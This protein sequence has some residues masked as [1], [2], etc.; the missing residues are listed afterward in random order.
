MNNIHINTGVFTT[1]ETKGLDWIKNIIHINRK[2]TND[3]KHTYILINPDAGIRGYRFHS[4]HI[5]KNLDNEI[6]NDN[7]LPYLLQNGLVNYF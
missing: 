6:V 5:D 3:V 4:I 7:I 1:D 2:S